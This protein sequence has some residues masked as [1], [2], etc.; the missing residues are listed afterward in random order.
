MIA[1]LNKLEKGENGRRRRHGYMGG[2]Q[3]VTHPAGGKLDSPAMLIS[4]K[5]LAR[6]TFS[7]WR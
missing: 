3:F 7:V 5:T 2:Y 1:K 6:T 4:R